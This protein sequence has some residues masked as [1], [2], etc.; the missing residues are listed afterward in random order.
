[1]ESEVRMSL[2]EGAAPTPPDVEELPDPSVRPAHLADSSGDI[3]ESGRSLQLPGLLDLVAVVAVV[4]GVALSFVPWGRMFADDGHIAPIVV[5]SIGG[6]VTALALSA[7]RRSVGAS[8]VAALVVLIVGLAIRYNTSIGDL[9][10]DLIESWKSLAS[11]GLL[12]PTS[13]TFMTPP[14]VVSAIAAWAGTMVVVRRGPAVSVALPILAATT[15]ALAYTV[16]LGGVAVWY[17][18]ALVAAIGVA[19]LVGGI[20]RPGGTD[21]AAETSSVPVRQVIVG[22]AIVALLAGGASVATSIFGDHADESFDLRAE[23]ARP[24]DIY[25]SATPLAS[26][27]SGLVADVPNEVFTIRLDGLPDDAEITLLPVATLDTYDGS[28][29]STT[30]QFEPAGARL[31]A[32]E[33]TVG[34]GPGGVEQTVQ[35]ES[36][37]P[38]RFLPRAGIVRTLAGDGLAWDPRSGTVA[39]VAAGTPGYVG[40]VDIPAVRPEQLPEP[41]QVP[42]SLRYASDR[43]EATEAQAEVLAAYAS[44]AVSSDQTLDVRLGLLEQDLRSEAFGYNE[45]APAGHSLAALTSY[46]RP[47]A[48]SDDPNSSAP[49]IG[50]SEQSSAVFALLAREMGLASRVV[51]GYRLEEPLT[52]AS[53]EQTVDESQIYAWP[54]VWFDGLGWIGFDPTNRANRSDELSARTPAVSSDGQDAAQGQLPE[55]Q[56]PVLLPP[57][58]DDEGRSP[59]W[60]L[61]LIP[62]VPLVY[63]AAVLGAKRLRR[64]RRRRAVEPD[65]QVMGAW[66]EVRDRFGELGL[67]SSGSSSALDL[68]E[69]L[70]VIDLRDLAEPVGELAPVIDDALYSPNPVTESQATQ[71]WGLSKQAIT[72]AKKQAGL[73]QRALAV[74]DPRALFH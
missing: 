12:I 57:E 22:A 21:F 59:L 69:Q 13:K 58:G 47:E 54:E 43:P 9:P 11:T 40:S 16:S 25:E 45:E 50:F 23:L 35:L 41:G 62:V 4:A 31:P 37:Y 24:L 70:D 65:R 64:T 6:A 8:F 28:V 5:A 20:H 63:A 17:P 34:S 46:L 67:P 7:F 27:K 44:S 72:A 73:K 68:S 1:M 26:V 49:R 19:L 30:A 74:L 38:F 18:A 3:V 29:W 55:F 61:L 52:A 51:V 48:D 60:W 39:S 66:R 53:P 14:T 2:L 42:G 71:A 10:S 33:Q 56:E 32:P 36:A 15:V